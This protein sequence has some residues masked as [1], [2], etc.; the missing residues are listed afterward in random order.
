MTPTN[1][2]ESIVPVMICGTKRIVDESIEKDCFYCLVTV[3]AHPESTAKALEDLRANNCDL[4]LRFVCGNCGIRE[5]TAAKEK[6]DEVEVR[7][8][9]DKQRQQIEELKRRG[10]L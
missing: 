2:D 4:P 5:L 7:P 8:L 6:G 10:N 1:D 9:N 3:Y